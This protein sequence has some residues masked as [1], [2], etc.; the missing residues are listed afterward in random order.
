MSANHGV[1]SEVMEFRGNA[2]VPAY[3]WNVFREIED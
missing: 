1:R 3:Q 2:L